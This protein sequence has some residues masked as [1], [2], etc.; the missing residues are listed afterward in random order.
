MRSI[1]KEESLF[2][3]TLCG[4][5]GLVKLGQ[6]VPLSN[7]SSELKKRLAGDDIDVNSGLVVIPVG[8]MKRPLGGSLARY[9]ILLFA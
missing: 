7:L 2:S 4:D 3:V 5:M 6:P 1:P 9:A 8:V